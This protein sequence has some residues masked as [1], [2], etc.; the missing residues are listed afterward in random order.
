MIGLLTLKVED[1]RIILLKFRLKDAWF[2][3]AGNLYIH[4]YSI[5]KVDL[6]W[7]FPV[8]LM[9][10]SPSTHLFMFLSN[11]HQFSRHNSSSDN[12]SWIQKFH[13]KQFIISKQ[14]KTDI[15]WLLKRIYSFLILRKIISWDM[16]LQYCLI[17]F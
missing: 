17:S 6:Y 5:E 3:R 15:E 9:R 1:K 16:K 2:S 4:P 8:W 14:F 12:M 13:W 10:Y 11:D 7:T